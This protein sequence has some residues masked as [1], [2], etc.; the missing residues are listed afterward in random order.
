M[1]EDQGSLDDRI[2]TISSE[3]EVRDE[4]RIKSRILSNED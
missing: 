4:T 3:N 1:L 2:Q